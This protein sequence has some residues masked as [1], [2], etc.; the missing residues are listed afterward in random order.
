MEKGVFRGSAKPNKETY[1][2]INAHLVP[3]REKKVPPFVT[4]TP[5][6]D[7]WFLLLSSWVNKGWKLNQLANVP[8][9]TIKII[10]FVVLLK[11][12]WNCYTSGEILSF[13]FNEIKPTLN[14]SD[15]WADI[16]APY[17]R[18]ASKVTKTFEG[19]GIRLNFFKIFVTPWGVKDT[20]YSV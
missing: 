7:F 8:Q 4:E 3:E 12:W 11:H 18:C 6:R 9:Q 16:M 10:W 17:F 19:Y 2:S 20:I 14:L 13:T 1:M 5:Y 15:R